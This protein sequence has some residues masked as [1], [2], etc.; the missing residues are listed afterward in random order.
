M[1]RVE[2]VV[3]RGG[4]GADQ[5]LVHV[6]R[7]LA[8]HH[9]L[10]AQLIAAAADEA[11]LVAVVD[12]RKAAGEEK[13]PVAQIMRATSSCVTRVGQRLLELVAQPAHDRDC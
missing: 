4:I 3:G 8:G 9:V 6:V 13:Q 11:L 1:G 7:H 10:A 2:V 12:D 5:V